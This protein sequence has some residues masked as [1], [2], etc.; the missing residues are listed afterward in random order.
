MGSGVSGILLEG[1]L[2]FTRNQLLAS[3]K[4]VNQRE[5]GM[6]A[7]TAWVIEQRLP[8]FAFRLVKEAGI[9]RPA[10]QNPGDMEERKLR[11]RGGEFGIRAS[12]RSIIR[13]ACSGSAVPAPPNS[14]ARS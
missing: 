11:S 6:G 8:D 9:V 12:A 5:D 13:C 2:D 10:I 7:A 14:S 4:E 1:L 3:L